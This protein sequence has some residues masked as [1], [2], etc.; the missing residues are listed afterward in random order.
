MWKA[1]LEVLENIAEGGV[2]EKRTTASGLLL[3][4]ESFEF[5]F[6]LHLMIQLLG[7]TNDVSQC[8]QRKD[9]NIVRA[10][11]L[12]GITLDKIND[13]RQHGWDE[14]FVEVKDFSVINQIIIPD[15]ED[16]L[17]IRGRSRDRGGQHYYH[18]FK[19]DIFNVLF[20]ETHWLRFWAQLQR[21]DNMK[22]DIV[23][24]CRSLE[25][26][27]MKLFASHG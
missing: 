3:Q 8:L 16:K 6:I 24:T 14:L 18:H 25:S 23:R 20:R 13:V 19:N 10:I 17:T 7:I 1:V 22:D 27:A 11:A 26:S 15:M 2:G 5:V 12:I 21:T 4:M 9:Q